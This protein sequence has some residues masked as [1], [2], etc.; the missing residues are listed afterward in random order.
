M[1]AVGT[2]SCPIPFHLETALSIANPCPTRIAC[3]DGGAYGATVSCMTVMKLHNAN[4]WSTW[5]FLPTSPE[6]VP[7]VSHTR[8]VLVSRA[9]VVRTKP[10]RT[11]ATDLRAPRRSAAQDSS[12]N[13]T[14]RAPNMANFGQN[15]GNRS[16]VSTL[17]RQP[18]LAGIAGGTFPGRMANNFPTTF[19]QLKQPLMQILVVVPNIQSGTLKIE[20]EKCSM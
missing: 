13:P 7:P 4:A 8:I 5:Y 10:P 18:E 12:R 19:G 16:N 3:G 17:V 11:A 1:E 20:A 6:A 9:R 2:C 14:R 15:L